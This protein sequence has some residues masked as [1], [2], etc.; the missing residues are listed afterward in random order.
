VLI[1]PVHAMLPAPLPPVEE[2]PPQKQA[3][4][5]L[6]L[7]LEGEAILTGSNFTRAYQLPPCIGALQARP[8]LP[9]RLGCRSIPV[10]PAG[11]GSRL[12]V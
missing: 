5:F 6:R 11:P 12:W 2:I 7:C 4:L 8:A 9:C 1:L 10:R 3:T